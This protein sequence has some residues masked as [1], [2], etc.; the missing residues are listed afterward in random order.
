MKNLILG[1]ERGKNKWSNLSRSL[2][3]SGQESTTITGNFENITG[4]YDRIWSMAES[5]LPLQAKLEKKWGIKNVSAE[6]A[7]ILTNK[8]KFDD[9]CIDCGLEDFIPYSVIPTKISDL[10]YFKNKSFIVKPIIGSGTKQNYDTNIAYFSYKNKND[11]MK[12]VPVDLLFYTNQKGFTDPDF[13]NAT[14]YYMVQ[15]HLNHPKVYAP[16]GY[17]NEHG[18][19]RHIF[20]FEGTCVDNQI[21]DLTFES[22]PTH[23]FS[24]PD[25]DL[26]PML[27]KWR[28]YFF[29]TIVDEL[30]IKSMFFAGPDFY[31]DGKYD[32]KII[33]C[34]PRLGGGLTIMNE[35]HDGNLLKQ[36]LC[37]ESFKIDT[38]F[39][40]VNADL[41][42]GKIKEVKDV[43]WLKPYMANTSREI[44]PGQL[45]SNFSFQC[46]DMNDHIKI[47]LAIPGK[48]K[49][50]MIETY[51]TLNNRL[52]SCIT[53]Y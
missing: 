11:F 24:V 41:K 27:L 46:L 26:P 52:Q 39:H 19:Y 14:N 33:D 2:E 31:Y 40:W 38:H 29:N 53:Y 3:L 6:A 1:Y 4:K 16:Y 22:K 17:V 10:D 48:K 50:D 21:D 23:W 30:K 34:N 20:T 13:N 7:A 45:I 18:K 44:K 42:P 37:N 51:R 32:M 15:E 36:A 12:R 47:V 9:F 35:L 43:S 8:K 25:S 28:D 5:L 49:S